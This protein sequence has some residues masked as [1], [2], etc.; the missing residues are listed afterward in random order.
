MSTHTALFRRF[1]RRTGVCPAVVRLL[2]GLLPGVL[3]ALA[4]CSPPKD[5]L[6]V[7]SPHGPDVLGDYEAKFEAAY[8]GVDVQCLDLGSQ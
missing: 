1:A 2:G 6:L 3:L 7:Y 8:P 4:G 5:M